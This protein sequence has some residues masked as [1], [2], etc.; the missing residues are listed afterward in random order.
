MLK[1]HLILPVKKE[2]SP[3]ADEKNEY[4]NQGNKRA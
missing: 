3:Y 2:S 4:P 1:L